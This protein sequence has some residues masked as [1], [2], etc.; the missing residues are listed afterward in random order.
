MKFTR[1]RLSGFKSFVEPTDLHIEPGLTAVIGP[2]GC[3]KSN[4]FDAMRWAMGETR[5]TSV[6]GSE[7]DDVIFSGSAGRPARNVAEVT[8]LIDNSARKATGPYAD[9]DSIEV[10]RRIEREAG[11]VYRIN[12]RDVRQRDVQI[13]FADASSGAASTAFV[14]QG[15]IGLLISQKPLARRAILEEAAGISGLHQRRHEAE[16]RLKAAEA[17]LARLEDVIREVDTQLAQ[18]KRQARQAS[19]YRNLS[20]HIRKAEALAHFL[21]WTLAAARAREAAGELAAAAAQV[22]VATETAART[23]TLQS[24]AAATL[25]PLREAEAGKSAAHQ[26]LIV[27]REQLDAEEVRARAAAQRLRQLLAQGDADIAREESLDRDAE[28]ALDNLSA[29]G[30]RLK[31]AAASAESDIAGAETRSAEL[32][33]KLLAADQALERLNLELSQWN[34]DKTSHQRGRDLAAG[35]A[36][37]TAAQLEEARERLAHAMAVAA[38][39]VSTLDSTTESARAASEEA[40][41]SAI[42]AR[43]N[44]TRAEEVEQE[45][46]A[47]LEAA[48]GDVHRVQGEIKALSLLLHPE[49]EGL[50]PPLIDAVTVQAGYEAA[51]A[52]ALG[53]DLQA[54]LDEASPHH[55][56]DLGSFATSHPL[57]SGSRPLSDFVKAPGTLERR[58]SM[59]G[60]VFPDQGRSLQ[61]ELKPGQRLVTARGDLWR[62]DGYAASAD[63]PSQATL[64]LSQRNRLKELEQEARRA[65]EARAEH[66]ALWS[67]AKKSAGQ[68]REEAR[69]AEEA[70]RRMEQAL[71]AAQD[72]STRTARA[73][74]ERASALATLEAEIRRLEQSLA[75]AEESRLAAMRALQDLGD[76]AR[77]S[78][79]VADARARAFEFRASNGEARA[80][81]E[82]LKREGEGRRERLAG[83]GHEIARWQSRRTAT[84][85]QI[86][87]LTRRRQ[88]LSSDLLGAE[89]VPQEVAGRRNALLGAIAEAED[90]RRRATDAR[91]VAETVL[92]EA[93]KHAKGAGQ[94]LAQAREERARAQAV[95]ESAEIRIEELRT[96]I[97]D[98]LECEAQELADRADIKEG[99]ELPSLEQAEKKVERLKQERELLGGVNLRAEEE[100]DEHEARVKSLCCDRDDLVGAIE[101]LRRGIHSLNRE[102]RERLLK[103]F[104]KVNRNFQDLFIRLFEGGEARLTFTESDDPLE[105]GLEIFARPPGKRLQSLALLSGGEQALT[106]LALI[107]AVFLVNPAPVCVLDEVDAPLDDANVER[108]CNLLDQMT[109]LSETRF[110]VITHHALTMSRMNRLFGVTMAERGVS[111]LVSVSL[112]EADKVAAE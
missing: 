89:R 104:E 11:S 103:S 12:G 17:N 23:S 68:T 22:A 84:A 49:G 54:P 57:P 86:S 97:H 30:G 7:M 79:S 19:R 80:G 48:E 20:G 65:K 32:D 81:L 5:P 70:E 36:G 8:L 35:L 45:M 78:G 16:L 69:E 93:D 4:L 28:T 43:D 88:E 24:E 31:Q 66:F 55:W 95:S 91:V 10:S 102:G 63:A 107:F 101:R 50:F 85:S 56:R 33:K 25:P 76:G 2:N 67:E 106:A 14:R 13:F 41:R 61:K 51:L 37:S 73:Q 58:L 62:W 9:F 100:A 40:K 82:A 52:A 74:A 46:R 92:A 34:A 108:F 26:R 87:E 99:D 59:T 18:L 42:R 90:Q 60:L 6:R 112:A 75:T 39:D 105:A 83:L 77:L 96:R 72:E 109:E 1:L 38:P 3:G 71:I 98:E 27:A 53:D 44:W 111:Q 64:R 94:V 29:E 21:R 47:P 110:L 15:Q